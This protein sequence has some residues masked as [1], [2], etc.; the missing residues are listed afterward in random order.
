MTR[1]AALGALEEV[2]GFA[3]AGADVI[4]VADDDAARR[5]WDTLDDEVAVLILTPAAERALHARLDE[6][7]ALLPVVLA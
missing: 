1:I 3:L 7:P 6:R 5:A 4:A 2:Q